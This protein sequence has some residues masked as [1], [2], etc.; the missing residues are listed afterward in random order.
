MLI[1]LQAVIKNQLAI[2]CRRPSKVKLSIYI[3]QNTSFS[4]IHSSKNKRSLAGKLPLFSILYIFCFVCFQGQNLRFAPFYLSSL[5]ANS[6]F[7][8]PNYS[9]LAPKIPLFNHYFAL[10]SHIFNGCKR[11]IYTN[12]GGFLCFSPCIQQ[13]FTLHLASKRI[14]FSIKTH[15]I[16]HQNA[17]RFAPY[18]TAFCTKTH[19][20]QRQNAPHLAANSPETGANGV[21][22]K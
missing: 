15:C 3:L 21:F 18:Q 20:I 4:S 11:F 22:I 14:A 12:C 2:F 16:Q 6:L 19:Y 9:L 10:F 5:V 7:F 17:R 8:A 13:H 1:Y